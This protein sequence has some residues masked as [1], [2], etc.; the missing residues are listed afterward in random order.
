MSNH[1]DLFQPR[2]VIPTSSVMIVYNVTDREVWHILGQHGDCWYTRASYMFTN[3][4][5]M[6]V[7]KKNGDTF[8]P[9]DIIEVRKYF[10]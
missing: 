5:P 9:D 4:G 8:T 7:R 6:F 1:A 10:T 3:S 2:F